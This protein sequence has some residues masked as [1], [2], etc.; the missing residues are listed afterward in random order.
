MRKMLI[1]KRKKANVEKSLD[2]TLQ[3]VM[4]APDHPQLMPPFTWQSLISLYDPNCNF[5]FV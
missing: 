4:H 2:A 5:I 1:T 3:K